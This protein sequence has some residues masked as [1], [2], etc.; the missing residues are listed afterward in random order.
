MPE[1][2]MDK[3]HLAPRWKNQVW[4]SRQIAAVEAEA[5]A[6][7]MDQATHHQLGFSIFAADAGHESG[8]DSIH[9]GLVR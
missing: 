3:N 4:T 9:W 2:A 1:A 8:S 7:R 5:V 6:E